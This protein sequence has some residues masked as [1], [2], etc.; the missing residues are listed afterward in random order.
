M[1]N[2]EIFFAKKNKTLIPI[3]G[4]FF[5]KDVV[6]LDQFDR[7]SVEKVFATAAKI[8]KTS[9]KKLLNV[10]KGKIISLLFFEPSTRTFSSHSAAAKRL[11]AQTVEHQNPMQTSSVVKGETVEDMI[12]IMEQYSDAIVIRH[13][14]IGTAE[15]SANVADIPVVNAG[16]G[17]GEHPTQA[18]LDSFTIYEK[19]GTLENLKGLFCGDFKYGR[20]LRSLLKLFS[21]YKNNTFYLLSPKELRLTKEELGD[22]KKK[23]LNLIEINSENEIPADCHFWYWTRIQKERFKADKSKKISMPMLSPELLEKKGNK[24]MIVMHVLPRIDEVDKRIDKDPR[25]I[26]LTTQAK[27]GMYIRMALLKLILEK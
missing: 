21:M 6:S 13:P 27:N 25:C 26:F 23:G 20:A 4:D 18:L 2:S 7:K 14:L 10:L 1:K 11:G 19:F 8:K 22:Y 24:K 16:D 3:N 15:R 12:K 17:A 5:L 9:T